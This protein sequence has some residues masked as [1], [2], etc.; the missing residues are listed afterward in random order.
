MNKAL[1]RSLSNELTIKLATGEIITKT[2]AS[3]SLF[4]AQKAEKKDILKKYIVGFLKINDIA[5]AIV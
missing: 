4:S 2:F 3:K 5:L 1:F